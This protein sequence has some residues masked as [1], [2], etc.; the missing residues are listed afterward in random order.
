MEH[1]VFNYGEQI[2]PFATQ[3]C[4]GLVETFTR[5]ITEASFGSEDMEECENKTLSCM[6]I[7]KPRAMLTPFSENHGFP[8]PC[9]RGFP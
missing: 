6:G 4:A 1:L 9:R 8:S 7:R 3:L 5:L 2:M